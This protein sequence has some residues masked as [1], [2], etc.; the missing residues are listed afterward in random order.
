MIRT[1]SSQLFANLRSPI[2]INA[3]ASMSSLPKNMTQVY[4]DRL[5]GKVAV[6]TAS[7]Q[8]IG[9]SI[10]KRLALE[11]A[12]VVISSRRQANVDKALQNLKDLKLERV[13]GITCHVGKEEDRL[14]LLKV[15][16]DHF[17]GIDILVSNAAVNPYFGPILDTPED[18][19]DKIFE[20]NVKSTFFLAK[21]TVPY[22]QERGGGSIIL[23]ASIA[24]F[25]PINFLGAYSISKTAIL[26]LTK[27]L[28]HTVSGEGIR[29]NGIAPG[30]IETKFSSALTENEEILKKNLSSV[31]MGRVGQP[32]ECA[33]AVAF[34]SSDD[35]SYITGENMVIAGGQPSRM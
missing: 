29:V 35:A 2:G 9:Y 11:G 25:L 6:V 3:A 4:P 30:I 12:S 33:G 23:V 1:L 34:L 13:H 27:A 20:I 5:K 18:A 26:G 28:S 24:G 31:S 32:D 15:A 17:G 21:E 16:K 14:N 7:T 10:A 22:L 19:W 8:G